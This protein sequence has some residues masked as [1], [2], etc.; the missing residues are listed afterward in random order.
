MIVCLP[1]DEPERSRIGRAMAREL[2]AIAQRAPEGRRGW[3]IEEING[4]PAIEDPVE[5][6]PAR[7]RL[8]VDRDG[9]AAARAAAP[10]GKLQGDERRRTMPEG[11]TIF[12]AARSLHRVLAGHAVTRFETAY[13]HLDRVN[14]DT[15]IVGRTIEK[16]ESAGK[17]C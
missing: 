5:P 2:V 17:H 12:R 13:A 4:K 16:C 1:D 15:P 7:G 8:H 6:V 14:V 3:L 9:T 10:A 11:D